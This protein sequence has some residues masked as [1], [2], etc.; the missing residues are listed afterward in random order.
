MTDAR[1]LE[2]L[3][4]FLERG[5]EETREGDLFDSGKLTAF[6]DTLDFLKELMERD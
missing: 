5:L 1:R 3:K 4:A 6:E 2:E